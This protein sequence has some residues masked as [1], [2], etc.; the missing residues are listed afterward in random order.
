MIASVEGISIT[1]SHGKVQINDAVTFSLIL[2]YVMMLAGGVPLHNI[3]ILIFPALY[4]TRVVTA[5][6]F[7][8]VVYLDHL[9][10]TLTRQLQCTVIQLSKNCIYSKACLK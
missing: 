5:L 1:S 3:V 6:Y 9:F 10:T 4:L 2:Q 7:T 8:S